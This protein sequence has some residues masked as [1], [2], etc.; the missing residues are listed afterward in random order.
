MTPLLWI[1]GHMCGPWLYAPL[2]GRWPGPERV[3]DVAGTADLAA[4]ADRLLAQTEGPLAVA[5]LS[6]GGM[7]TMEMMARAPGGIAG[8]LLMATDPFAAREKE[9]AW[10]AGEM[11]NLAANGPG[12]YVA[13]FA[14]KFFAHDAE[15]EARLGPDTRAR[16]AAT[17]VEAIRAEA[18]ALDGR[19]DVTA[20][21]AGFPAPVDVVSG[22]AD[23]VCPARLHP[24]IAGA[25]A[26]AELTELRACGHLPSLE[27]PGAVAARLDALAARLGG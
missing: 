4:A 10:R 1:P 27:R 7:I 21:L 14:G 19:A 9:R 25:C 15:A 6:M 11:A 23:R 2:L 18:G 8:A 16:M 17:P 5:G 24:P 12:G 26:D 20:R 3:A 22:E 13:R